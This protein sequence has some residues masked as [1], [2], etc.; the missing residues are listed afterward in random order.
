VDQGA[1][2]CEGHQLGDA[3][4]LV[5]ANAMDRMLSQDEAAKLI[6]RLERGIPKR[7]AAASVRRAVKRKLYGSPTDPPL[8]QVRLPDGKRGC[9]GACFAVHGQSST[10]RRGQI[11]INVKCRKK[12]ARGQTEAGRG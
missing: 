5:P 3:A 4:E 8:S 11:L 6:R 7:P 10:S 12:A 1:D 9:L 2:L